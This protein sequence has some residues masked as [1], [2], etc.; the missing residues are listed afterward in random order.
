MNLT[1]FAAAQARHDAAACDWFDDDAEPLTYCTELNGQ[2][3]ELVYEADAFGVRITEAYCGRKEVALSSIDTDDF[4]AL[5][6][7]IADAVKCAAKAA[8]ADSEAA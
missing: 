5:E 1:A 3:L 8:Q 4:I 7:E 2:P 6:A